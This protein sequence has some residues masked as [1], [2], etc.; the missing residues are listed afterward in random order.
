[1]DCRAYSINAKFLN[2]SEELVYRQGNSKSEKLRP[3][4]TPIE[5]SPVQKITVAAAIFKS[6]SGRNRL[7]VL[8]SAANYPKRWGMAHI[9]LIFDSTNLRFIL[10]GDVG[11]RAKSTTLGLERL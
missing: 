3:E 7:F 8:L 5:L 4:A 2:G 6:E 11:A 1:M 10:H 9:K